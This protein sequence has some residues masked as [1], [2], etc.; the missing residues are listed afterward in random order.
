MAFVRLE[1]V[2]FA[3]E[4]VRVTLDHSVH[5]VEEDEHTEDDDT[6]LGEHL[7][8]DRLVLGYAVAVAKDPIK[9]E[10]VQDLAHEVAVDEP[11]REL[12]QVH[13][14]VYEDVLG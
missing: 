13:R 11:E 3:L 1:R 12:G 8:T 4:L 7:A 5:V 6:H 9:V 2:Q 14:L 10:A